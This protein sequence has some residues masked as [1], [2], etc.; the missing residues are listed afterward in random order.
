[1]TRVTQASRRTYR[2]L[3]LLVLL[4]LIPVTVVAIALSAIGQSELPGSVVNACLAMMGAAWS[5]TQR[6]VSVAPVTAMAAVFIGGSLLW[7][8]VRMGA[9]LLY[10]RWLLQRSTGCALAGHAKLDPVL[11]RPE[12]QRLPLRLLYSTRPLAFTVGLWRPQIVLSEG[13]VSSLTEDEVRAVL[14]HEL[15]HVRSRDPMRLA[16]VRFLA[17][18]LWFLPVAR[19]LA[20]DFVDAVE[21]GADDWAVEAT[22]R[23]MELA[24]A[25]VKTARAG[26]ASPMS[27]ASALAGNLSVE[28]RVERLLGMGVERRP[29]AT[30]GR[31]VASGFIA[32]LLLVLVMLPFAGREA[33]A[34]M[35]M[36]QAMRPMGTMSCSL[37]MR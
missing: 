28:D 19:S 33:A 22:R 31:W 2:L 9:S 23:P 5:A 18:A 32:V 13:M 11:A 6:Q 24:A 10:T 4:G 35:A 30:I 17:D 21:E 3:A 26:V 8:L 7:A 16:V 27:L 1:M 34:R 36:E 37:S 20:K 12:F 14:F 29:G 25:L 15:G